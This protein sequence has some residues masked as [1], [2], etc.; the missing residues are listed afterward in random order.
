MPGN[1]GQTLKKYRAGNITA[2]F[3]SD[4]FLQG[5]TTIPSLLI[6]YYKTMKLTESEVMLLIHLLR[7]RQEEA[8]LYPSV[9]VLEQYFSGEKSEVE[10]NLK[11]LFEKGMLAVTQYYH[12]DLEIV[13]EGY[14]FEPL[15]EKI[16]EIWACSKLKEIQKMQNVVSPASGEKEDSY[17]NVLYEEF[18]REFG[19]PLSPIEIDQISLWREKVS[20]ELIREALRRAVLMGK[21]NFKYIDSILLEW[22][23]NNIRTVNEVIEYEKYFQ[24][25]REQ[26]L[27][28][29]AAGKNRTSKEKEL[30][31]SLYL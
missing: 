15:F 4:L 19:R 1:N 16:S 20:P 6:K 28:K 18:A 9:D 30:L 17:D 25:R 24:R 14:D 11:S 7:L 21:H 12:Q 31:K 3:G 29:R 10:R 23:K 27:R 13:T 5:L 26:K 2:A 8:N 22:Q